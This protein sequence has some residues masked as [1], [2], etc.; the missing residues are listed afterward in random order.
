M[1]N[2]TLG[3][4]TWSAAYT[5]QRP[6]I[7]GVMHPDFTLNAHNGTGTL[8]LAMRLPDNQRL[9]RRFRADAEVRQIAAY[10]TSKGLSMQHHS[11]MRSFPRQVRLYVV[12]LAPVCHWHSRTQL[13]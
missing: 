13:C 5:T 6:F 10:L 7:T 3:M 2:Q 1:F 11:I 9:Q 4:C 12:L 8:Q